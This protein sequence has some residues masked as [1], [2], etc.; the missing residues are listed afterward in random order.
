MQYL[1]LL[2]N[3]FNGLIELKNS[4]LK[5]IYMISTNGVAV[6]SGESKYLTYGIQLAMVVSGEVVEHKKGI[7]T[8]YLRLESPEVKTA[9]FEPATESKRGG[10]VGRIEFAGYIIEADKDDKGMADFLGKVA[11]MATKLGVLDAVNTIQAS[12]VEDYVDKLIPIV[13]GK[14]AYWAITG[15]EY[16][17]KGTDKIGITLGIRRYGFIASEAEGREHLRPFDKTN[18][19]DYKSEA[20]PSRDPQVDPISEAFG[21]AKDT[22]FTGAAPWD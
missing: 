11:I 14:F 2:L 12:T 5:L 20:M 7:K 21:D 10:K 15:R 17:K 19:Y 3:L 18:K 9:G 1:F 4:N 16:L 6:N 8:V 22:D 13:R